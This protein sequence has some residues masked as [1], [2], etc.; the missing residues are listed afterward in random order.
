[1]SDRLQLLCGIIVRLQFDDSAVPESQKGTL[2]VGARL[3]LVI[4]EKSQSICDI[5]FVNECQNDVVPG[6]V[7]ISRCNVLH[8]TESEAGL[9]LNGRKLVKVRHCLSYECGDTMDCFSES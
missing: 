7:D 3:A 4:Y 5:N 8:G 9:R 6:S 2:P 1:M